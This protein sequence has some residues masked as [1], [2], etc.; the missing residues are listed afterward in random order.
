MP[1]SLVIEIKKSKTSSRQALHELHKYVAL[2]RQDLEIPSENI[3]CI[4]ISTEWHELITSFAEFK[5]MVDFPVEG[6]QLILDESTGLPKER[7]RIRE[8]FIREPK[9][10][11]EI[12]HINLFLN[13]AYRN[14]SIPILVKQLESFNVKSFLLVHSEYRGAEEMNIFPFALHLIIY[15]FNED[16]RIEVKK[17]LVASAYSSDINSEEDVDNE[18]SC[19]E[20]IEEVVLSKL[21]L[22]S[23]RRAD[24]DEAYLNLSLEVGYPSKFL[25]MLKRN[26]RITKID[27]HGHPEK[28][29]K[30]KTDEDLIREIAGLDGNNPG[31]FSGIAKSS[32]KNSWE[33]FIEKLNLFLNYY[34]EWKWAC[35]AI[36]EDCLNKHSEIIVSARIYKAVNLLD[37]LCWTSWTSDCYLPTLDVLINIPERNDFVMLRGF[38]EWDRKTYPTVDRVFGENMF[39]TFEE[40][41]MMWETDSVMPLI[42]MIRHGIKYS[43]IELSS[44]ESGEKIIKHVDWGEDDLIERNTLDSK[45][46]CSLKDFVKENRGYINEL[47]YIFSETSHF[48]D[49]LQD[50]INWRS[51]ES[52]CL[53]F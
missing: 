1:N 21:S 35:N 52:Y 44:L 53:G 30:L 29:K 13:D 27:R 25:A 38:W 18:C 6:I 20:A 22:E 40:C 37:A 8:T 17:S 16:E 15:E 36:I 14:E 51:F 28:L 39:S 32:L 48:P 26:W 12:H 4:I 10:I 46:I 24:P 31:L 42:Q 34:D 41:R 11:Y 47:K 45:R 50:R 19:G 2:L 5:R 7:E 23:I 43:I 3:R 33:K 49:P 9:K